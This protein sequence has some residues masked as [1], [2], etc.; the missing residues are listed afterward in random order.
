MSNQRPAHA[1][2]TEVVNTINEKLISSAGVV[3]AEYKNLN[4]AQMNDL[5]RKAREENIEIKVYKD[6]LVR[7]AVSSA[8]LEDLTEF[9][10]Q[11]NVYLFSKDN[12]IAPVKLVAD[13]AKENQALV[14]KAGVYE[15][16]VLNTAAITEIAMLPS[17]EE[18]YAMFANSLLYPLR[19]FMNVVK[20]V[21]KT[22][23]E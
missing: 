9:L 17:K 10:T 23:A 3:I 1:L 4:V 5:R 21:A 7:R 18:L 16:K 6:S 12:P 14:L 19:Q 2:K 13:F 20:E 15:G 11:Q 22:K 8:N